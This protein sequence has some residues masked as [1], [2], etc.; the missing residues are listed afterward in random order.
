[1]GH[2]VIASTTLNKLD[3]VLIHEHKDAPTRINE[4]CNNKY[5]FCQEFIVQG[6]ESIQRP[7]GT[8]EYCFQSNVI[9]GVAHVIIWE[10]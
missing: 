7:Y 4:V 2:L 3:V 6:E 9:S 8:L 10:T 1:M 5:K